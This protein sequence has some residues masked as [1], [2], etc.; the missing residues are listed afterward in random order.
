MFQCPRWPAKVDQCFGLQHEPKHAPENSLHSV[1]LNKT[2]ISKLKKLQDLYI[3]TWADEVNRTPDFNQ[4]SWFPSL[5]RWFF[6]IWARTPMKPWAPLSLAM[7]YE[8]GNSEAAP[9]VHRISQLGTS[10]FWDSRAWFASDLACDDGFSMIFLL[11]V[12]IPG[13]AE[14]V[15]LFFRRCWEGSWIMV[16]P[17][18]WHQRA[19]FAVLWSGPQNQRALQRET[20]NSQSVG[21]TSGNFIEFFGWLHLVRGGFD[22][23]PGPT[24]VLWDERLM[25]RLCSVEKRVHHLRIGWHRSQLPNRWWGCW[26]TIDVPLHDFVL[27]RTFF[28]SDRPGVF[29]PICFDLHRVWEGTCDH[30]AT[31]AGYQRLAM[32]SAGAQG[33]SPDLQIH[34]HAF[35][36]LPSTG[37]L[38]ILTS[39]ILQQYQIC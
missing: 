3:C 13:C 20:W 6:A 11:R 14:F 4:L 7:L 22:R 31:M 34:R 33:Q 26:A 5:F 37:W 38:T 16:L 2:A 27:D 25:I 19:L 29:C 30:S 35:F 24:Q 36:C 18:R 1:L 10:Q 39:N 9:V 28:M 32:N 8:S 15:E 17:V 23:K 21:G 12:M